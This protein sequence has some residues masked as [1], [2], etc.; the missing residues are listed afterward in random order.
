M[1][2]VLDYNIQ[3]LQ[4]R[5]VAACLGCAAFCRDDN[6]SGRWRQGPPR[7]VSSRSGP[8][9]APCQLQK[10]AVHRTRRSRS[11]A[12]SLRSRSPRDLLSLVRSSQLESLSTNAAMRTTLTV[13]VPL[14]ARSSGVFEREGA[15]Q[16]SSMTA[17]ASVEQTIG[18][19]SGRGNRCTARL[20][21]LS[22]HP[23]RHSLVGGAHM[24][25]SE[26]VLHRGAYESDS[27]H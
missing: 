16:A 8:E 13:I 6:R 10:C 22:C 1:H 18:G 24:G 21:Q 4:E 14:T 15:S 7:S 20:R 11:P 17:R 27:L 19:Q 12:G 25:I 2:T 23:E 5:I 3:Q 26:L 9:D